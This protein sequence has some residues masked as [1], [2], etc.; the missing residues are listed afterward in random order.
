MVPDHDAELKWPS[1]L[2]FFN[3]LTGRTEDS[4]L[5]F[6]G[7]EAL[8]DKPAPRHPFVMSGKDPGSSSDVDTNRDEV[9]PSQKDNQ[10]D[11]NKLEHKFQRSSTMPV[12]S[13][14]TLDSHGHDPV[15]GIYSDM[16]ETF[17][18]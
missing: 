8:G 2:S 13:S 11:V 1:G 17:L 15:A 14:S 6:S 10:D 12:T 5:L 7:M 3:A 4:K 18:E 16:M 9:K